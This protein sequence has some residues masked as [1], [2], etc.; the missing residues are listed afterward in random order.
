MARLLRDAVSLAYGTGANRK[1]IG[2]VSGIACSDGL[3]WT[4]SDEGRTLQSLEPAGGGFAMLKEFKI[5]E[6]IDNLPGNGKTGKKEE[7]DLE[8]I[9]VE[10]G[11]I[12]LAGSHARVRTEREPDSA[13][14]EVECR[15]RP[16]RCLFA[17]LPIRE[18]QPLSDSLAL[19]ATGDG[20]LRPA[21]DRDPWLNPF[22]D[23]PSKENGIDIEGLAIF[24]G[25]PIL[26][27]R[28]P[29]IDGL[30]V[31]VEVA[32]DADAFK[33]CGVIPHFLDLCGLGIRDLARWR[34]GLAVLAGPTG[35]ALGPFAL[36]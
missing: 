2:N 34:G 10:G 3:V 9:D 36:H 35:P 5:D 30:A 31:A 21:L 23:L 27:L 15:S 17:R 32:L 7:L 8:A 1:M 11:A 20:A 13:L 14:P 19:P 6:L 28:G 29:L 18:S 16:S 24:G 12:W 22:R 33:V 4:V 25:R 26:G